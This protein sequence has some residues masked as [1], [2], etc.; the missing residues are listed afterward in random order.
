MP[1]PVFLVIYTVLSWFAAL[2]PATPGDRLKAKGALTFSALTDGGLDD[3]FAEQFFQILRA[4]PSLLGEFEMPTKGAGWIG[5]RRR[6]T[7]DC[8]RVAL[9]AGATSLFG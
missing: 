6:M 2:L 7:V 3:D 9:G 4:R 8:V 5:Q 1:G